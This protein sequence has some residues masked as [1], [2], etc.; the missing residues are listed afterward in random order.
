MEQRRSAV[1]DYECLLYEEKDGIATI[2]LNRPDKHNSFSPTQINEVE[3]VWKKL[4]FNDDVRVAIITGAGERAFSSGIDLSFIHPQ[5]S[6]KLML[7]D[8]MLR[9]G[10]KTNDLW[11]PVIA[12]VNGMACGGA[13]Y[14]LGEAEF[15]VASEDAT[16]FDPHVTHGMPCV[17]E[18]MFMLQRMPLGEIMRL[19][20]LG[21]HERMTAARAHQ[22]GLVQE[23][24]PQAE[25]LERARWAAK[26]IAE[27]PDPLAIEATV[28]AIWTAQYMGIHQA[29]QAAPAL[30]NIVDGT[31][32]VAERADALRRQKIEPQLR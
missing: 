1:A 17:Y 28:K 9:I 16:F 26:I 5:P 30:I 8:P 13:F 23:V 7:N 32:M 2:T 25:L 18:P 11:K 10:P 22:V 31:T 6:S 4:R 20:L 29:L 12:A 15:I 14:I 3:D 27:S 19:S 21:R 24:V